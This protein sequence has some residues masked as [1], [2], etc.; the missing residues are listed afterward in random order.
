MEVDQVW[1]KGK[2]KGKGKD[3]KGKSKSKSKSDHKGGGKDPGKGGKKGKSDGGNPSNNAP[4]QGECSYCGRW[5]HK[6]IDCRKR[7]QQQLQQQLAQQQPQRGGQPGQ[8][9]QAAQVSSNEGQAACTEQDEDVWVMALTD[10]ATESSAT[11]ILLDSGSDEHVAPEWFSWNSRSMADGLSLRDVQGH[12]LNGQGD[13][14]RAS[15]CMMR[16]AEISQHRPPSR[17]DIPVSPKRAK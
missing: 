4:F 14:R 15:Q 6:R 5:G 3:T 16:M 9:G 8:A 12:G 11:L 7:S 17:S 13:V 10:G 1:S 2:G